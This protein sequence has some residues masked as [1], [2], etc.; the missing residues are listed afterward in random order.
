MLM[1]CAN[2]GV[3]RRVTTKQRGGRPGAQMGRVWSREKWRRSEWSQMQTR[4]LCGGCCWALAGANSSKTHPQVCRQDPFCGPLK[5]VAVSHAHVFTAVMQYY[6]RLFIWG[7]PGGASVKRLPPE[8][9]DIRDTSSVPRLGR[10]PGKGNG[11]PLQYSC[12]ENPMDG[13]AWRG[14]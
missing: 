8:A 11:S 7:F 9:G 3:E 10:S 5:H 12:L 13:G 1:S 14:L 4:V 6:Y 2:S